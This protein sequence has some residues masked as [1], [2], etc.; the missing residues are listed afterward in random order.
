MAEYALAPG[1]HG[2]YAKTTTPGVVDTV[3]FEDDMRSVE[4]FSDGAAA[5]YV[6]TDGHAPTIGDPRSWELPGAG[7]VARTMQVADTS[8]A[9]IVVKLISGGAVV[10]SVS[11]GPA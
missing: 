8:G 3:T 6:T 1:E 10:Y 4:V 11:K 5:L 2:A 9:T 7:P